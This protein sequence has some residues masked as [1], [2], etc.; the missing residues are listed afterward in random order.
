MSGSSADKILSA[1]LWDVF[2]KGPPHVCKFCQQTFAG[3]KNTRNLK[4]HILKHH[5]GY[6]EQLSSLQRE[7]RVCQ[8]RKTNTKE[9][10]RLR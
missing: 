7:A 8:G 3:K 9:R 4:N 1:Y 2:I 10:Q 5:K 6:V